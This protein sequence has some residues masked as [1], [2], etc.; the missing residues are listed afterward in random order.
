MKGHRI[1]SRPISDDYSI[2]AIH[3]DEPIFFDAEGCGKMVQASVKCPFC[4]E[5]DSLIEKLPLAG[6]QLVIVCEPTQ[7]EFPV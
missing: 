3:T 1:V 4:L 7:R 2:D 5:A 6:E